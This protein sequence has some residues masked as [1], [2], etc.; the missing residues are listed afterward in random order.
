MKNISQLIVS[1]LIKFLEG[2][3][4]FLKAK[5]E[6]ICI[7]WCA[8]LTHGTC[9]YLKIAFAVEHK[10][11][12]VQTKVKNIITYYFYF[13][14]IWDSSVQGSNIKIYQKG[15]IRDRFYWI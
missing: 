8:Y 15:I 13:F 6:N 1:R 10:V 7:W 11:V 9:F 3:G 5:N 12:K 2:K 4:I 14:C